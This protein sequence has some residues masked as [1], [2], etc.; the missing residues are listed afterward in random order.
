M[1]DHIKKGTVI[2][3]QVSKRYRLGAQGTLRGTVSALLSHLRNGGDAQRTLWALRDVSF[4]VEPGESLGLIG[5]N[6]AGKTTALKLL[7]G[8]TQPT[9]G[10]IVVQGR[11]SSLIELGAGFHPELTGRDNTYLNGAILGLKRHE[12]AR[13]LDDIIAFSELERFID[14]PVKR[15]SS[16]MYVRLGFAVAAHVEPDVLLVDEV[17]AVGDASFR[18]RCIQHMRELQRSGTTV[19]FV[20]HNM[21]LV[22]DVC[23]SA[24]L[25]MNGQIRAEGE[26]SVVISEYE[27]LLLSDDPLEAQQDKLLEPAFSSSGSLILTA[28]EV[29]PPSQSTDNRL[30]SHLPAKVKIHYRAPSPQQIGRV[31][32]RMVR[33]DSTLCNAI[34]SI[35]AAGVDLQLRKVSGYGVIEVT[36]EPLQ[37]TAGKYVTVVRITDPSDCIVIASGQSRPFYVYEEYSVPEPGVFIPLVHW[38][39]RGSET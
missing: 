25:L 28:V 29:L 26:P 6:G 4:R 5:P 11:V 2:F 39:K 10:Q 12:I 14:T 1:S 33:H 7:S 13:K 35:G 19:V 37:L 27:R 16:G 31:D 21:H 8:I 9:T 3:D 30:A 17:L 36:Y 18:H 23:C 22:R 34:D 20:S 15:Y 32:I 24:L 38:S